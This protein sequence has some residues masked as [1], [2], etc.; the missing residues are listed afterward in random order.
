RFFIHWLVGPER[1]QKIEC[2]DAFA[3]ILAEEAEHLRNRRSSSAIRYDDDDAFAVESRLVK[4]RLH[5]LAD[6]ILRQI[7]IQ[8]PFS[9]HHNSPPRMLKLHQRPKNRR[10]S[11]RQS[12]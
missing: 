10:R 4:R 2:R 5:Q 6:L 8:I 12:R 7:S 1:D 11:E 9:R 3:E